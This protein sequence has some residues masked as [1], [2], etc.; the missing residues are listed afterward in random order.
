MSVATKVGI[1]I[2]ATT[3]VIV[4]IDTYGDFQSRSSQMVGVVAS[5]NPTCTRYYS[6]VIEQRGHNDLIAGLK[7]YMQVLNSVWLLLE[8]WGSTPFCAGDS[9]D[10]RQLMNLRA[11]TIIYHTVAHQGIVLE[12]LVT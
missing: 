5:I 2:N 8:S 10:N 6:H 4:R 7:S 11:D 3:L 9:R 1:E 12:F